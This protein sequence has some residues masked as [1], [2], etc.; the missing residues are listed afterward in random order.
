MNKGISLSALAAE[1]ERQKDARHDLIA[2]TGDLAMSVEPLDSSLSLTVAGED[3]YPVNSTAH[4]QIAQRLGIPAK[5]YDRMRAEAPALL[6]TNVNEWFHR[7]PE[8]RML[9]TLDGHARAFLSDRY[10]RI[11]NNE[12]A[13]VALPVLAKLPEVQIVSSQITEHR[14]YIQAVTPRLTENVALNDAVQA[15]VIVSN[16]EIGM[17]SA[18]VLPVIWRLRCLNGM[19]VADQGFRAMHVGR[20]IEDSEELWADDTRRADDRA[21]LLKVRDMIAAAVD[22]VRFRENVERMQGL[23]TARVTGNPTRVVEVLAKR[24]NATEA[25]AGGILKSLIEGGDLSAWGLLNAVTA[26]AHGA[27]YDRAVEFEAAG[28][29]LLNLPSTEWSRLLQAA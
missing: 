24:V 21:V 18:S 11:D 12:I 10:Q 27:E 22:A 2:S 17:G 29:Q 26:Q 6:A 19:V 8:R 14:M 3:I 15:G 20:R 16:S 1:I 13:E 28:G 7:K 25:E 23:A 5:Y 9:R 4:G